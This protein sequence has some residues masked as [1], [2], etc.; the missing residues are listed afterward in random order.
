M[1]NS[2]DIHVK[3][4]EEVQLPKQ[5]KDK[6][7]RFQK[8]YAL[9]WILLPCCSFR[10]ISDIKSFLTLYMCLAENRLPKLIV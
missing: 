10:T 8:G 5:L 7:K 3:C 9:Q 1:R 4:L 6:V 2:N